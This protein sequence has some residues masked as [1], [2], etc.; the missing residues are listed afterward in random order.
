MKYWTRDREAGNKIEW[1]E[2]EEEAKNAV[3]EYEEQDRKG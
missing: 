2:T 3:K 1:F